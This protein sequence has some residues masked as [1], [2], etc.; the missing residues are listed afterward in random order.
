MRSASSRGCITSSKEGCLSQEGHPSN[1]GSAC[2]TDS[3]ETE[4]EDRA[5]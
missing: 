2:K 4:P 5:I 1:Y 3:E